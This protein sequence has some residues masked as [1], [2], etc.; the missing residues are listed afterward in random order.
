L[1]LHICMVTTGYHPIFPCPVGAIEPYI[2]GLSKKLALTNCV[3]VFGI[4][5]GQE[6]T[7]NLHIQTFPYSERIPNLL[8][9]VCGTQ[10]AYQIPFNAYLLESIFD[11]NE[12]NPIDILHIHDANSG[13]AATISKLALNIKYLFSAHNELRTA[14]TVRACDKILAVSRYIRS[15]LVE[16]RKLE[17]SKVD[18]LNYG[19]EK[20]LLFKGYVSEPELQRYYNAADVFVCPSVWNEPFGKVLLEALSYRKPVVASRAGGIPEIIIDEETGLLTS[21]GNFKELSE[22]IVRL[23]DNPALGKELGANGRRLVEEQFSF[24]VVGNRCLE[25]YK[26][27]L[28]KDCA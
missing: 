11:L 17:P 26:K 19:V 2:Y 6:E 13:F 7:G 8:K 4:G 5:K 23:L 3:D 12:K 24:D 9:K 25:I 18:I 27:V 10:L 20:H 15:F 14:L 22:S 28:S 1:V 16:K 21:P